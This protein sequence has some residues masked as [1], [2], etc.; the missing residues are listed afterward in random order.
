MQDETINKLLPIFERLNGTS[1][2]VDKRPH[3]IHIFVDAHSEF[4][5]VPFN[6]NLYDNDKGEWV[7]LSNPSNDVDVE[8][9]VLYHKLA[10]FKLIDQSG[11]RYKNNKGENCFSNLCETAYEWA[12]N[13]LGL[14][15]NV[16]T[17]EEFY[18]RYDDTY[19]AYGEYTGYT[20]P[21]SYLECYNESD[22]DHWEAL[23]WNDIEVPDRT[24]IDDFADELK[25]EF[26]AE[27]DEIIPSI[28]ADKIDALVKKY[29]E[30][31][32]WNGM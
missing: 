11:F 16:I 32:Q 10:I 9:A 28:M 21:I 1:T 23:T 8:E 15:D 19:R 17:A 7:K 14:P 25:M 31:P 3:K 6:I 29:K 12:W 5:I 2:F 27:F 4:D 20:P 18:K 26:F 24:P 13:A 22:K 30:H